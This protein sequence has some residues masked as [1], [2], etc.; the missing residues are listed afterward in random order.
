MDFEPGTPTQGN[1]PPLIAALILT[2]RATPLG[3]LII[4]DQRAT[5]LGV[6][7]PSPRPVDEDWTKPA[8]PPSAIIAE[9]RCIL[10]FLDFD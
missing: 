3:D 6:F 2:G 4:I 8:S 5:P 10:D 1:F 9:L 7:Q